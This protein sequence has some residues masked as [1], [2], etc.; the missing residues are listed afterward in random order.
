MSGQLQIKLAWTDSRY[1]T[2][3]QYLNCL[4]SSDS[5]LAVGTN[6]SVL[7]WDRRKASSSNEATTESLAEFGD[8]H[9]AEVTQVEA[10]PNDSGC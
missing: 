6:G 5:L 3:G 10:L 1:T 4:D 8:T 2:G 7:F 9:E